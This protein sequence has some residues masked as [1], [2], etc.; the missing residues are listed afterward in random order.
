MLP[1]LDDRIS[2]LMLPMATFTGM[3]QTIH[4]EDLH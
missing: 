4:K 2:V 3:N 1:F